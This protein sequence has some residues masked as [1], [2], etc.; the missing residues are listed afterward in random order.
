AR[1]SFSSPPKTRGHSAKERL[2][3]MSAYSGHRDQRDRSIVI[4]EIVSDARTTFFRP[5]RVDARLA[6]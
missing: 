3:V 4:A 1:V 5:E 6:A 2:L